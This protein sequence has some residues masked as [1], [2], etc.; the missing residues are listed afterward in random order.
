MLS[1]REKQVYDLVIGGA[2]VNDVA[3]E[4]GLAVTSV[5]AYVSRAKTKLNSVQHTEQRAYIVKKNE[6]K[7]KKATITDK[8]K[9]AVDAAVAKVKEE[10][11]HA[12]EPALVRCKSFEEFSNMMSKISVKSS[13]LEDRVK[14]FKDVYCKVCIYP[15]RC[16]E[17]PTKVLMDKYLFS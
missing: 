5:K 1:K 14:E 10:F 7:R 6:N 13:S 3:A 11:A 2:D 12:Q 9:C 16:R 8:I 15:N 4:L 17:C